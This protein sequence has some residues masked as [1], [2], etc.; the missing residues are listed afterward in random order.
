MPL[1]QLIIVSGVRL[2][3]SSA[4]ESVITLNT[5]PGSNGV[6]IAR[7]LRAFGGSSAV[8]RLVRIERRIIRHRQNI[9]VVRI[10][11][12]DRSGLA[13][14]SI[15]TALSSSFSASYCRFG[16][17]VSVMFAPGSGLR[18]ITES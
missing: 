4:A 11:R 16:S 15:A 17:M 5:L 6:V 10:H 18:A 14:R 1:P 7:L 2:V 12:H 3:V 9:A 13:R 8:G